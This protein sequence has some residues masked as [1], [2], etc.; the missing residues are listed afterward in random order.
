M[1]KRIR[2]LVFVLILALTTSFAAFAHS[3]R[4]DS[5][6]GHKDNKNKS[7]LGPYHYHCGGHP[8]HLHPNGVCPY[9]SSGKESSSTPKPNKTPRPTNT[10]TPTPVPTPRPY[11]YTDSVSTTTTITTYYGPSK[12][13][14][15]PYS[16]ENRTVVAIGKGAFS[17][18][19][20]RVVIPSS[21]SLI[22]LEFS[23]NPDIVIVG[24]PGSYAHSFAVQNGFT[25]EVYI[26]DGLPIARGSRG[27][28]VMEVQECLI[29]LGYLNGAADGIFG[30][31]T[32][33]SVEAFQIDHELAATGIVDED[34]YT[35]IVITAGWY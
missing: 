17:E 20:T 32:E 3:G 29:E 24:T 30:K 5:N 35:S 26:P 7:G 31:N 11:F 1:S 12:N 16:I 13:V 2:I 22:D 34:C 6:G 18:S 15:I 19:V 21:V 25:F 28:V 4:T 14:T 27:E 33:A 23:A 8:A 10:P 9:S